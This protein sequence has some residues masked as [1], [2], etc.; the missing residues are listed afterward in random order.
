MRTNARD[1]EYMREA[2]ELARRGE[3]STCPNAAVGCVIVN[4]DEMNR[5]ELV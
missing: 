1:I 5:I 2:L 3:Y 4:D